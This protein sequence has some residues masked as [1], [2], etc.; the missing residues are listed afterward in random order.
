VGAAQSR[1][2]AR[3]R[4]RERRRAEQ[5]WIGVG[6]GAMIAG[7]PALGGKGQGRDRVASARGEGAG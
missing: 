4:R 6:G 5:P 2:V 3:Q 7:L 1:A